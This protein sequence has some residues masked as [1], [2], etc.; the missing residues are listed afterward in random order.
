MSR[1]IYTDSTTLPAS[2]K[3]LGIRVRVPRILFATEEGILD[4]MTIAE[5]R[6]VYVEVTDDEWERVKDDQAAIN[7][8]AQSLG[9]EIANALGGF[10]KQWHA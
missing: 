6:T 1:K 7:A 3:V 9:P 8:L 2:G 5:T 4:D 10:V